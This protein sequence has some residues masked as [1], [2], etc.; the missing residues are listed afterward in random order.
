MISLSMAVLHCWTTR[1]RRQPCLIV[2]NV[3]SVVSMGL[4]LPYLWDKRLHRY[5]T[6]WGMT[7]LVGCT[8]ILALAY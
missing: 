5:R 3:A 1:H 4:S 2:A 7:A 6:L 8:T